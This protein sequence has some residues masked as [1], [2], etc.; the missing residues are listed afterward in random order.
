MQWSTVCIAKTRSVVE[1]I[2][3]ESLCSI[4]PQ[5]AIC[6]KGLVGNRVNDGVSRA[7]YGAEISVTRGAPQMTG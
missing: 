7:G 3:A 1:N 6:S 2:F 5:N 4:S